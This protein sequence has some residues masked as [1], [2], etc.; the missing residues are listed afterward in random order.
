MSLSADKKSTHPRDGEGDPE[1]S[2]FLYCLPQ[3]QLLV[4]WYLVSARYLSS[5][6]DT[7]HITTDIEGIYSYSHLSYSASSMT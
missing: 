6:A 1:V 3:L 4:I 7:I 2:T 5:T